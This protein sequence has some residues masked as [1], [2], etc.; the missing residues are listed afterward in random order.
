MQWKVTNTGLESEMLAPF[1]FP[2]AV[3]D[4]TRTLPPSDPSAHI[5]LVRAFDWSTTSFG[6]MD[7]WTADFRQL[8]NIITSSP[9]PT[10]MT[11]LDGMHSMYNEFYGDILGYAH[12]QTLGHAT[13]DVFPDGWAHARKLV[14]ESYLSGKALK[15]QSSSFE[16]QRR[17]HVMDETFFAFNLIPII[18]RTSGRARYLL[19]MAEETTT[20]VLAE[21]RAATIRSVAHAT[22]DAKSVEEYWQKL[23]SAL[24]LVT[25][26]H[27][28]PF[29]R[30]YT[31][32]SERTGRLSSES[33]VSM[34]PP[35]TL[36]GF[37]AE[38]ACLLA[39]TTLSTDQL[40]NQKWWS[41]PFRECHDTCKPT[42]LHAPSTRNS[43]QIGPAE[44][45]ED[46]YTMATLCPIRS[47]HDK[48]GVIGI[49][50]VGINPLRPYD[51]GY[52]EFMDGLSAQVT[53]SL[54][55]VAL[56]EEEK[57]LADQAIRHASLVKSKLSM[58]LAS[59][60]EGEAQFKKLS[61]I[62]SVGMSEY[63][64]I[65]GLA[66]ALQRSWIWKENPSIAIDIGTS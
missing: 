5:Q 66:N 7:T 58:Q 32:S 39:K 41:E 46:Q 44:K 61:E 34:F 33:S 2:G 29:A 42:V 48:H 17:P 12:P 6:S 56:I 9:N 45:G 36:E 10:L 62:V 3:I 20:K 54:A 31:R 52:E 4:W 65:V 28:I 60:Q 18:D 16:M 19:W 64:A 21:R 40:H 57:S 51:A 15:C 1:T 23:L 26:K 47:P 50:L 24:A 49:L 25:H 53:S 35:F 55:S 38:P 30:L 22:A 37:V 27:E 13:K 43:L 11:A 63:A 8:A 59:A 14:Y